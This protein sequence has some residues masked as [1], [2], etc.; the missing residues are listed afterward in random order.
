M[1]ELVN[2]LRSEFAGLPPAI[3]GPA[4]G[5]QTVKT[6]A[7]PA[8]PAGQVSTVELFKIADLCEQLAVNLDKVA[9]A[10]EGPG[11]TPLADPIFGGGIPLRG[12]AKVHH[13]GDVSPAEVVGTDR[14]G[15]ATTA[16]LTDLAHP[17][18][19]GKTQEVKAAE[20]RVRAVLSTAQEDENRVAGPGRLPV[21]PPAALDSQSKAIDSAAEAMALTKREAKAEPKEDMGTY[22]DE[23]AMSADTDP[24]LADMFDHAEE[25]G[26]KTSAVAA[27]AQMLKTASAGCTCGGVGLCQHCLLMS[28]VAEVLAGGQDEPA[29]DG[30]GVEEC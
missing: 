18:A 5:R 29:D 17:P 27:R 19:E 2:L 24:V 7:A 22:L 21:D 6:A 16:L 9:A 15:P 25:A 30:P 28:K 13:T 26:V 12:G 4:V 8:A 1:S 10:G 11:A 14:L 23:P 20:A 3:A